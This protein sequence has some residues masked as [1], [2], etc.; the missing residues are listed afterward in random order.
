MFTDSEVDDEDLRLCFLQLGGHVEN[1]A[2]R[3]GD[4]GV[5]QEGDDSFA[6]VQVVAHEE[7][8][9]IVR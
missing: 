6:G 4:V 7:D 1:V 5:L 2:G 3:S 8:V 9:G